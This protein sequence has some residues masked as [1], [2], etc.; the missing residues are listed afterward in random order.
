MPRMKKLLIVAL[1]L[2]VVAVVVNLADR[3]HSLLRFVQRKTRYPAMYARHFIA[4]KPIKPLGSPDAKVKITV[5]AESGNHCHQATIWA[6]QQLGNAIPKRVYIEF[7]DT[8]G[9]EGFEA[10][11]KAG[12]DCSAG[13][14]IDGKKQFELEENGEVLTIGFHGPLGMGTPP[15]SLQLVI[16]HELAVKYPEG[17]TEDERERLKKVWK[18]LPRVMD[19]G[20][21]EG[22]PGRMSAKNAPPHGM[23]MTPPSGESEADAEARPPDGKNTK[24]RAVSRPNGQGGERR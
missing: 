3:R 17:L 16:E 1:T 24:E 5:F 7:Q 19:V 6:Y 21:G 9:K 8:A 10:A 23:G 13:V 12:V 22:S 2:M 11:A 20:F 15:H 14:V 4:V 18:E